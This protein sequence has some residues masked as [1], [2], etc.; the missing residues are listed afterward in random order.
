MGHSRHQEIG[1]PCIYAISGVVVSPIN[2]DTRAD[3]TRPPDVRKIAV[4]RKFMV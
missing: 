4:Q 2:D 3:G 1:L